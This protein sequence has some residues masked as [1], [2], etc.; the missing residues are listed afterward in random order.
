M[1]PNKNEVPYF[2]QTQ[3]DQIVGDVPLYFLYPIYPR[4]C[5]L[6]L[7]RKDIDSHVFPAQLPH[8]FGH[9]FV[10]RRWLSVVFEQWLSSTPHAA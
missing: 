2:V 6:K 10:A 1:F 7:L 3:N 5:C 4:I 8:S 9:D